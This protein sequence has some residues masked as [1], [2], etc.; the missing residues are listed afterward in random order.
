MSIGN[1][2]TIAGRQAYKCSVIRRN[3]KYMTE[4]LVLTVPKPNQ[5]QTASPT[6]KHR[7]EKHV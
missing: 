5:I 2:N 4:R 3:A 7:R 6:E 1:D